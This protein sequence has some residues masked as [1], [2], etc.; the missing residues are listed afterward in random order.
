MKGYLSANCRNSSDGWIV[1]QAL[2]RRYL[3][4]SQ[5]NSGVPNT[6]KHPDANCDP[7]AHGLQKRPADDGSLWRIPTYEALSYT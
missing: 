5:R 2:D 3:F 7:N 6:W 4:M 1:E